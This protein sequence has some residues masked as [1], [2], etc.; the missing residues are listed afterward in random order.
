MILQI[1]LLTIFVWVFFVL[2]A[3]IIVAHF[4]SELRRKRFTQDCYYLNSAIVKAKVDEDTYNAI[5][6][7]FDELECYSDA[8]LYKKVKLRHKFNEK[9]E[10]I[11]ALEN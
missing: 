7:Q 5:L 10:S 11:I 8:D 1:N 3:L 2:L 6:A 9:F 4:V